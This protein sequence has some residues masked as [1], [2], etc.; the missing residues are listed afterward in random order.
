MGG[1]GLSAAGDKLTIIPSVRLR[2]PT[3]AEADVDW[4][5]F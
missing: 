1:P 5:G 4:H 3:P 2:E